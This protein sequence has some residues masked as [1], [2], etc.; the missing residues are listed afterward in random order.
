MYAAERL[1]CLEKDERLIYRLS[2]PKYDGQT[3]LRLTPMEFL[4][5]MAVLIPPPPVESEKAV[6]ALQEQTTSVATEEQ[7]SGCLY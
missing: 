7:A 2:K 6:V 5:R 1:S 3:V 4:D